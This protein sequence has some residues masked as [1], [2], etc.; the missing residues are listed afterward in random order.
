MVKLTHDAG[1]SQ[2]ISSLSIHVTTLQCFNGNWDLSFPWCLQTP[3]ADFPKFTLKNKP[4]IKHFYVIK[5]KLPCYHLEKNMSFKF[6][7]FTW[8]CVFFSLYKSMDANKTEHSVH[9]NTVSLKNSHGLRTSW[10]G[11]TS[12]WTVNDQIYKYRNSR[13]IEDWCVEGVTKMKRKIKG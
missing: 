12:C 2:K 11:Y 9:V 6:A 4:E 13:N 1:F 3:T 10:E 8:K 7:I 5:S